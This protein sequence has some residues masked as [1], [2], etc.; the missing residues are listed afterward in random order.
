MASSLEGPGLMPVLS[1][2]IPKNPLLAAAKMYFV[3]L[4]DRPAAGSRLSTFTIE[5]RC[6]SQVTCE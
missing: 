1:M 3:K 2:I 4:T 6:S 5:L